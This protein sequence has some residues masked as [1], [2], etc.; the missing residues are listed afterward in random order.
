MW[1]KFH[2]TKYHNSS[3]CFA[4]KKQR[5]EHKPAEIQT[6][7]S[8]KSKYSRFEKESSDS[9]S[10]SN[11]EMKLVRLV[12]KKHTSTKLASLRIKVQLNNAN[13]TFDALLDSGASMSI[14]NQKTL[15]ANFHLDVKSRIV[16]QVSD[17][18]WRGDK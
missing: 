9:D 10:D 13:G 17:G 5:E 14:I 7:V 1:C 12:A 2:K 11:S 3:E 6:T 8:S 18:K 16:D 4:L 15:Q